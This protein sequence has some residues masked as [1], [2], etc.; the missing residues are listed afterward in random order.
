MRRD[1]SSQRDWRSAKGS[2]SY[3]SMRDCVIVSVFIVLVLYFYQL[4]SDAVEALFDGGFGGACDVG[5]IAE[6]MAV[7][8]EEE[9]LAVV[10]VLKTVDEAVERLVA[11]VGGFVGEDVVDVFVVFHKEW[12]T[13]V[14]ADFLTGDVEG[15]ACDPSGASTLASVFGP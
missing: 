5:D 15:D 6:R 11:E 14:L 10:V 9:E 13:L 7:D 8:V 3:V 12:H 1:C 2:S 4:L